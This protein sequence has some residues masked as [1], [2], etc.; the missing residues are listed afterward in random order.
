MPRLHDREGHAFALRHQLLSHFVRHH[1]ACA[2]ATMLCA[3]VE[4]AGRYGRLA[5]D[6]EGFV[7]RFVE[8]DSSFRGKAW[9]NAGIYFVSAR[10]LDVIAAGTATSLER[11]VF[12]RLPRRS[13]AAFTECFRFIDIGT[14]ESL[15]Q[16]NKIFSASL[17]AQHSR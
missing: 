5:L 8:K 16:A 6:A 3:E 11:D 10:L 14:P 4:D 2:S 1:A 17:G 12:E 15:A 7:E 9:I 13:L